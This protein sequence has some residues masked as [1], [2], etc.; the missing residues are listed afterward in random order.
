MLSRR[1]V[2]AGCA[3]S[4]CAAAAKNISPALAEWQSIKPDIQPGYDPSAELKDEAGLWMIMERYQ[5]A[6]DRSPFVIRDPGLNNYIG[7]ITERLAG[8]YAKDIKVYIVDRPYFNA[9]MAPNGVMQIWSGLLLRM[10]NEAQLAAVIGHEIGH[11]LKKHSLNRYRNARSMSGVMSFLTVG[12]AA[13]G[14]G[15]GAFL[16]QLL[17]LGAL[18]SYSRSQESEAD[19]YGLQLMAKAGYQPSAAGDVWENVV[20]E[21]EAQEVE[22]GR[23]LKT[24]SPI[25]ATHPASDQRLVDLRSLQG[26]AETMAGFAQTHRERYIEALRSH[27]LD[28]IEAQLDLNQVGRTF[29]M[30]EQLGQDSAIAS[31][32]AFYRGEVHRRR[33]KEGDFDAA[34]KAYD[35][36]LSA[37]K[38]PP[39]IYRS[40][41]MIRLKQRDRDA[42]KKAF[43]SYLAEV[44]DAD[45]RAMIE[46][47][48]Q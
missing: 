37:G 28:F 11:F 38:P 40:I 12:L 47:Y 46:F 14:G 23:K 44:P 2:V 27:R 3:C 13:G 5:E 1:H 39:Q 18:F 20:L 34:L 32:V 24:G 41:G 17:L 42:A 6:L 7:D 26:Q 30:L 31:E 4:V 21:D 8:P 15:G 36:A 10:Q 48:M 19:R 43:Q 22:L 35:A 33:A 9:T 45:D 29:H 16:T 25:L